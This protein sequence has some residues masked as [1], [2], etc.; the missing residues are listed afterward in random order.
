MSVLR[1][2]SLTELLVVIAILALLSS[3]LLPAI[4]SMM[5][6][7]QLTRGGEK[8]VSLLSLARQTAIAKNHSIEVRFYQFGDPE[9]PGESA[10]TP[11]SGKYRAIQS[12][13]IDDSGKATPIGKCELMTPTII[14]DSG[15]TL[16]TLPAN[17]NINTFTNSLDPRVNI[18]RAGT[19]YICRAFRFLSDGS[20]SSA[21]SA[22]LSKSKP[23]TWF[24]TL[25]N[26][27]DGDALTKAPTNYIT[28]QIDPSSGSLKTWQP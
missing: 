19:N 15:A 10:A 13:E 20:A 16:S 2:F 14:M 22:N 12:F 23:A 9:V 21:G 11:A 25:H 1:G 8:L 27:L 3:L 24:V 26:I 6:G 17:L 4:S 28:V 5:R 18:P 7:N